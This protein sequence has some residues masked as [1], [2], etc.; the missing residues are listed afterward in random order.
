M[1]AT[2]GS[3]LRKR[4]RLDAEIGRGGMG[5]V[6][7][8]HD[9]LLERAV[10]VKV[11]SA[12]S[13]DRE[14]R[15]RLLRE[16]QAAAQLNHPNIASVYDAGEAEGVPF[17]VM[18]LVEGPSLH[19]R[20]PGDLEEIVEL[21]GQVCAA[22][23]HAH[24]HGIVH[25]DL[26]P[27]NVLLS[28]DGTAKLVDFGLART[29]ASRLTT[30]GAILGTLLYLAPEQAQR[31]EIDGRA[32]LYALGVMLYEWATGRLPFAD[33]PPAVIL[34]H[35]LHTPVVPPREHNDGIPPALDALIVQ[36][37]RKRPEE[38]PASAAEVR[39][40]LE[41]LGTPA[42]AGAPGELRG[43]GVRL[44][45]FLLDEEEEPEEQRPA[46]VARAGE[47]AWLGG[48]LERALEGQ[49][50]VAFVTG[51]PGRGKT[52]LL[53]A[54]ARRAMEAHPELLVAG[55]TCN[56]YSGVGDAYLPFREVL[57]LLT[58]EVEARWAA[59]AIG[60]EQARRLW[61]APCGAHTG[62]GGGAGGP[63]RGGLPRRPLAGT[64]EGAGGARPGRCRAAGTEL[65]VPAGEQR[66]AGAS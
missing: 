16:A 3:L 37:L 46:F 15:A 21:A 45:R 65:P 6:Y 32:D 29:V 39:R 33:G 8:G 61:G 7:H 19:D 26:K 17:I 58:G 49:G 54:F 1:S 53:D 18:E 52:A 23:G 36:L 34:S 62:P 30:E 4:Y 27:E 28:P 56:A 11:L 2:I 47:L 5:V 22:L 35:H 12:A 41:A 10:A 57:S 66:A 48:F 25:R 42:T 44:P 50:R 59:G 63:G 38:R 13:L 60:R 24:I 55:G 51:G 43:E 40:A 9:T 64:A 31:G 20:P 14:S